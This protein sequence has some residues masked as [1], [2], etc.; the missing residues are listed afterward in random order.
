MNLQLRQIHQQECIIAPLV[1]QQKCKQIGEDEK[2]PL[3]CDTCNFIILENEEYIYGDEGNITCK[4]C[5]KNE[6]KK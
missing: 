6:R 2:M 4:E 5:E 1:R 3:Y